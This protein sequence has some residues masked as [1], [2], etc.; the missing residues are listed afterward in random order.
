MARTGAACG[1][2]GGSPDGGVRV[3]LSFSPAE[4]EVPG[5]QLG[6]AVVS[7]KGGFWPPGG[8]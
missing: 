5:R 7:E 3:V 1:G 6:Q 2:R 4:F 8:R